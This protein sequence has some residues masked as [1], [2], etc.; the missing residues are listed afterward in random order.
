ML[1]RSIRVGSRQRDAQQQRWSDMPG[2]DI[3]V[4]GASAGGVEA[5]TTLV[6][7]LP[8]NLPA[9]VF[10]VLHMPPNNPSVLPRILERYSTLEVSPA[11]HGAAIVP[12][13]I[14]VARPDHHLLLKP[15]MIDLSRGPRENGHR[16]AVDP[17]FRTASRAY[18]PRVIGV[19][20][21]GNLDDGTAGLLAIKR[22]SGL[23][24]VQD[25]DEAMYNGMPGS[26]VANV[27]V[28]HVASIASMG[29][30]LARLV[31]EPVPD[32]AME[33]F[34][35][36]RNNEP[37]PPEPKQDAAESGTSSSHPAEVAGPP[38]MFTCPECGGS[39]WEF[40]DGELIRFRC[41]VG[42]AYT[43]ESMLSEQDQMVE[44]AMWTALRTLEESAALSRR[45]ETRSRHGGH[46]LS[47]ENFSRRAAEA[48]ERAATIR[49]ALVTDR[50]VVDPPSP[51]H[52][53]LN[54]DRAN[55][56]QP[57]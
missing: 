45:L 47:A 57:E 44:S 41:H 15:G 43:A 9:A 3:I 5:L 7:H 19:V 27:A 51:T 6:R 54:R 13:R 26:A 53:L 28:D 8:G 30:L 52:D 35:S 29:L 23:A 37:H 17:L 56:G 36:Q 48:E 24:V 12:G 14:Y 20:L 31:A 38:S 46:V 55:S 34:M 42:H 39:L 21:S 32:H 49:R 18:G 2:H 16:P 50:E 11:A 40:K 33:L 4:V 25:P 1:I 10:V 22:R